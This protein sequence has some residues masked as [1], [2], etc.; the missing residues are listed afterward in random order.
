MFKTLDPL[1]QAILTFVVSCLFAALLNPFIG[2]MSVGFIFLLS[3]CIAGLFLT[4]LYVFVLAV[5]FSGVHNYFFIPPLYTFSVHRPEDLAMLLMFFATAAIV[6]QLTSRL[7]KKEEALGMREERARTLYHLT[8]ELIQAKD[9]QDAIHTGAKFL[10]DVFH[11]EAFILTESDDKILSGGSFSEVLS[12]SKEKAVAFWVLQN[13]QEA[14][15]FTPRLPASCGYYLPLTGKIGTIGVLALNVEKLAHLAPEQITLLD[16]F[17]NHLVSALDREIFHNR[18]KNIQ[19]YEETQKLYKTLLE[20]VS[21]ELKT[22]IAAI[23]GCSS[24]ILDSKIKCHEDLVA[25]LAQEILLGA[26]R[27]QRIVDNL[28]DM[29]RIEAGMLK[30]K[31]HPYSVGDLVDGAIAKISSEAVHRS[32]VLNHAEHQQTVQCDPLLTEQ[33]LINLL[34]NAHM[35]SPA[36]KP[37]EIRISKDGD[38]VCIHV[39]DYGSG[40]DP[41]D[42][43]K[44]FTKFYR[45]QP[46]KTGGIGLGLAIVKN[47]LALQGGRIDAEN[48]P[49][50]GAV[51][52]M[53]LRRGDEHD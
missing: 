28:L 12:K 48:H 51:F 45:A 4:R 40:L 41:K 18:S 44:I 33:A 53:V 10:E 36:G 46:K 23:K 15:K 29:S 50:G 37:I 25:D 52:T 16:N 35:Y 27:L 49:N 31:I 17:A 26:D 1:S 32:F 20:C 42:L 34:V 2:Y 11:L 43:P 3:V 24:A 14:G 7:K 13:G 6:G 5:L 21:H 30:L 19:L 47:I 38:F 8:K 9:M 39:R 22:P